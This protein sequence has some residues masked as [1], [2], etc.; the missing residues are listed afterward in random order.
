MKWTNV[1]PPTGRA[2]F[3]LE[4]SQ[5]MPPKGAYV[6]LKVEERKPLPVGTEADVDAIRAAHSF[7]KFRKSR[8][9]EAIDGP[10]AGEIC[11]G[12]GGY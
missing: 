4:T 12:Q 5:Y 11:A 2:V 7:A 3:A 8:Y 10:I 6:E 1:S 9:Q